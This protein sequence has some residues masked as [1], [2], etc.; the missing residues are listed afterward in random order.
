MS[1]MKKIL[2]I[3]EWKNV[4]KKQF[5][6]ISRKNKSDLWNRVL[7]LKDGQIFRETQLVLCSIHGPANIAMFAFDNVHVILNKMDGQ[8][9]SVM[10]NT[11][12]NNI[13]VLTEELHT[14]YLDDLVKKT[15]G[16]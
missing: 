15:L 10:C 6:V 9:N 11:E 13:T 1:T 4:N 2:N 16:K 7:R 14:Q 5:E 12:I 8:F 3:D